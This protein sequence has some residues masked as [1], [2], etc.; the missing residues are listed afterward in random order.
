MR[1]KYT[2]IKEVENIFVAVMEF[3]FGFYDSNSA[4]L[5]TKLFDYM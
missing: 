3:S 5:Q 2:N 1:R 4:A